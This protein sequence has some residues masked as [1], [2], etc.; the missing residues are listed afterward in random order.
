M[1][2]NN[3]LKVLDDNV[4]IILHVLFW[5]SFAVII[6]SFE[7]IRVFVIHAIWPP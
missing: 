4:S 1:G 6:K 3:L 7:N 5:T 2:S